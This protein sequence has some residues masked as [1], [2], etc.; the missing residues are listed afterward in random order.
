MCWVARTY[1]DFANKTR[2][3]RSSY[4]AETLLVKCSQT[5]VCFLVDRGLVPLVPRGVKETPPATKPQKGLDCE[6][7]GKQGG[8]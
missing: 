6:L 4:N 5:R 8:E 1:T 7:L 2:K 3:K